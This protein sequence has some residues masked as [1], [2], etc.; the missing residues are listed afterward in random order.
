MRTM[1]R[2]AVVLMLAVVAGAS[3]GD[4]SNKS[5]TSAS[6]RGDG[7]WA[8]ADWSVALTPE[9]DI[10]LARQDVLTSYAGSLNVL[11]CR[12]SNTYAWDDEEGYW[13]LD[14]DDYS[15]V[16]VY[17]MLID[18]P[19]GAKELQFN[20]AAYYEGAEFAGQWPGGQPT[21]VV[22]LVY[23]RTTFGFGVLPLVIADSDFSVVR[24][25]PLPEDFDPGQTVQVKVMV[26]SEIDGYE[27]NKARDA[28]RTITATG[29]FDNFAFAVPEPVTLATLLVGGLAL[30]RRRR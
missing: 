12:A 29:Y 28:A 21:A 8:P 13:M 14:Q 27:D 19:A 5:F 15:T 9:D 1:Q 26:T 30:L 22:T 6:P 20:A 10:S 17:Q 11:A 4:I 3:A 16:N 25:I 23:G 24:T 7:T 2:M 18:V